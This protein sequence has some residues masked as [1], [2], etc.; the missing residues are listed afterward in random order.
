MKT[1]TL[2]ETGVTDFFAGDDGAFYT[3]VERVEARCRWGH[4]AGL[5]HRQ[6][7]YTRQVALVCSRHVFREDWWKG[8]A[9]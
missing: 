2:T 8:V 6:V 1:V 9:G 4:L 5:Y 7:L 3:P